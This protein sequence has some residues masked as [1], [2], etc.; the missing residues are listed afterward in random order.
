MTGFVIIHVLIALFSPAQGEQNQTV[1][2]KFTRPLNEM[3]MFNP[4]IRHNLFRSCSIVILK[5]S[6]G[7]RELCESFY[8]VYSCNAALLSSMTTRGERD[9]SRH[10]HRCCPIRVQVQSPPRFIR[11]VCQTKL[12]RRP[13]G[14]TLGCAIPPPGV[15]QPITRACARATAKQLSFVTVRAGRNLASVPGDLARSKRRVE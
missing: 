7:G 9:R 2:T 1:N 6:E 14:G 12:R 15:T 4:D 11:A 10:S 5:G 8:N 13:K 3:P